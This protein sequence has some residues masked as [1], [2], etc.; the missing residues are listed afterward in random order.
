ML[1]RVGRLVAAGALCVVV[2]GVAVLAVQL[3]GNG[4]G[5]AIDNGANFG[6]QV[7]SNPTAGSS[8]DTPPPAAGSATP[9]SEI[10][11]SPGIPAVVPQMTPSASGA[12]ITTEA[13]TAYLQTH[14]SIHTAPSSITDI[15]GVQFLT[16][17]EASKK[18]TWYEL[19][20]NPSS[21]VCIAT[22][23]GHFTADGPPGYPDR[24]GSTDYVV[25]DAVTGNLL[26]DSL[27][28]DGVA[29]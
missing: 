23:R 20:R 18:F 12:W 3:R 25:F 11:N 7:N 6:A 16:S 14:A 28:L 10:V 26:G 22:V 15:P 27:Q 17:Q 9:S 24:V 29:P 2:L 19:N 21:L 5:G 8:V 4:S 1:R 13:V